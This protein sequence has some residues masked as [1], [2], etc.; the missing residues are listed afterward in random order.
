MHVYAEILESA[1]HI[2]GGEHDGKYFDLP[3]AKGTSCKVPQIILLANTRTAI[4]RTCH[5]LSADAAPT[6]PW[7]AIRASFPF[8]ESLNEN[9][10][11]FDGTNFAN[12][13][14]Q[15]CYLMAALPIPIAENIA[16]NAASLFGKHK[17]QC[18][19]TIEFMA[20]KHFCTSGANSLWVIFSQDDGVRILNIIDGLP[21]ST[22]NISNNKNHNIIELAAF[23]NNKKTASTRAVILHKYESELSW[24]A[25]LLT[26]HNIP[27]QHAGFS[28][29]FK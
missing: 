3:L 5:P 16:A 9:T 18:L 2:Y 29:I 8:G 6:A 28:S 11:V 22:F 7:H 12:S 15:E 21:H 14:G 10:H 23:T 19:N 1:I 26:E 17:L 24:I 4:I 25:Q 13:E 27:L 20:F